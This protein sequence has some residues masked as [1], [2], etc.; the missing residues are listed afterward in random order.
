LEATYSRWRYEYHKQVEGAVGGKSLY[1][2]HAILHIGIIYHI[3]PPSI[4][5]RSMLNASFH[6][7]WCEIA[8]DELVWVETILEEMKCTLNGVLVG[9]SRALVLG[10][11]HLVGGSTH[12]T[13]DT[14]RD[15]VLAW[16]VALGLLLVALLGGLSGLAL[17]G[18]GDVVGGVA[19][20]VGD[21]AN[22]TLVW[23]IGVW[24]RHFE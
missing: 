1:L 21:L 6:Q 8:V 23:L 9:G 18:L 20:G 14:V 5:I 17:D 22:D 2:I 10:L 4:L 24:C 13:G 16:D 11:V 15:G 3:R 7:K 12:G 19:D